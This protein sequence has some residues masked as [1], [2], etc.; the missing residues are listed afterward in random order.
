MSQILK[1]TL[2]II[3]H[4]L[5]LKTRKMISLSTRKMKPLVEKK[6]WKELV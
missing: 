1:T 5:I 4:T 6:V 2:I 3:G